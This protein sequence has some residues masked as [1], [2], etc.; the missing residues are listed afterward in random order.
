MAPTSLRR[1]ASGAGVRPA[2]SAGGMACSADR[3]LRA[4]QG[5]N[6]RGHRPCRRPGIGR[7]GDRAVHVSRL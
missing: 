5:T 4:V 1:R 6:L 7:P 2:Q 3:F